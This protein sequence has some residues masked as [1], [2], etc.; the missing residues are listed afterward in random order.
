VAGDTTRR[1][2][3]SEGACAHAVALGPAELIGTSWRRHYEEGQDIARVTPE[4]VRE[5]ARKLFFGE[6]RWGLVGPAPVAE[7]VPEAAR[8]GGAAATALIKRWDA[9]IVDS[10]ARLTALLEEA[11]LGSEPLIDAITTDLTP[12]VLPWN[13]IGP[14]VREARD[15]ISDFWDKISDEMSECEEFSHDMM[16]EQGT[17]RDLAGL[18]LDLLHD[19]VYGGV[20]ARA[21]DRMREVALGSDAAAHP[22]NNCGAVLNKVTPVSQSLNVE[23]AYCKAM[24]TVHPGTAL[25]MFA[26][27][28]VM[29]LAAE[30]ARAV[31]EARQRL[32]TRIKQYRDAKDV[33]LALLI[34]LE[35]TTRTYW[36]TRLKVEARYNPDEAKYLPAKLDRYMKDAQKTLRQYWQWREYESQQAAAPA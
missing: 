16:R 23:C 17:K 22:C 34:E 18:E 26:A 25:R 8:T 9:M 13:T 20:M 29:H 14:R 30:E 11:R 4:Q 36:T 35:S 21:A 6:I 7:A 31:N 5:A 10:R 32:E 1:A 19:Q 3:K 28:G 2:I 27:S 12:L 24:N 15:E 33:P